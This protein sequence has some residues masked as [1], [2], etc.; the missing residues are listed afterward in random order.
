MKITI[1][2]KRMVKIASILLLLQLVATASFADLQNVTIKINDGT[3]IDNGGSA[4]P[5][6][7]GFVQ[8]I[9]GSPGNPPTGV[10]NGGN[11]QLS[12]PDV[13]AIAKQAP[14]ADEE[15]KNTVGGY[16]GTPADAGGFFLDNQIDNTMGAAYYARYW[17]AAGTYYGNSTTITPWS[18]GLP[19]PA[20][21]FFGGFT[22]YKAAAPYA[23]AISTVNQN[24][25]VAKELY[26][27]AGSGTD[28]ANITIS[29]SG[30]TSTVGDKDI[31][32]KGDATHNAYEVYVEKTIAGG[33]P[34]WVPGP[35]LIVRDTN[36]ISLSY[37]TKTTYS[38]FFSDT[39]MDYHTKVVAYNYFG[40]TTSLTVKFNVLDSQGVGGGAINKTYN[41]AVLAPLGVNQFIVPMATNLKFD[42]SGVNTDI[43][44]VAD[45][46]N[47][48]NTQAGSNICQTFGWWDETRQEMV[49]WTDV[50][51]SAV[52]QNSPGGAPSAVALELDK[53]YQISVSAPITFI[54]QGER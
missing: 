32:V 45:L 1:L 23:L 19:V 12:G 7:S 39:S 9:K 35:D 11:G 3:A 13:Y 36:G 28:S 5:D 20:D 27:N 46:V 30:G 18:G 52:A 21:I 33:F 42:P 31:Q 2:G 17:D 44:D 40:P 26:P 37:N 49:G 10:A 43:N 47:A 38:A 6:G 51:G 15:I 29:Y 50:S 25:T 41:F 54:I 8:I 24:V 34:S 53:A 14:Y 48:I 4:I 16:P 22:L